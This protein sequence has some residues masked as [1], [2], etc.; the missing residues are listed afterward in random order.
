MSLNF[1]E[2]VMIIGGNGNEVPTLQFWKKGFK[3]AGGKVEPTW[4]DVILSG[5]TAL[6]L[7]NSK[8]NGLNYVK[9]FGATEQVPEEYIDSVT[10]D[11]KCEQRNLPSEYTQVEYLESSGT[12]YIDTGIV[13]KSVATITTVGQTP[14]SVEGKPNSFWGF[15]GTSTNLPRW[16]WAIYQNNW[17]LDLNTTVSSGV[18][19]DTNKHTFV[20]YCFLR[21]TGGLLLY[22]ASVD[23]QVVYE[24]AK[25]VSGV[26]KYTSN[27]LSAYLFARNNN[28]TAG[29]FLSCR[30]FSYEIVQ[31]GIKVLSLIPCRRNSDNVL[32]MYDTVTDTFLTNKGTGN[33]TAGADVTAPTPE[34]PMDIICN[35]GT[36]KVRNKSGLPLGYQRVKYL[37]CTGTQYINTGIYANTT[38]SM[39]HCGLTPTQVNTA[40][41][42]G[43][44]NTQRSSADSCN[45]FTIDNNFRLDWTFANGNVRVAYTVNTYY[46]IQ[47]SRPTCTINGVEY[48]SES[49]IIM[50]L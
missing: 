26:A 24:E 32:G 38:K 19:F 21:T 46:D 43:S 9:L 18:A 44:R 36:I 41:V 14:Q 39:F 5:N 8:A 13:L 50:V 29:N 34:T 37:E 28:N 17:L 35:N 49:Y 25:Q 23:G 40:G 2:K 31:D 47:C 6:T 16:G 22:N 12:Q 10:L 48:T 30:I 45:I 11:G 33:F 20:N 7:V 27:T 15:M 42:F 3:I 4:R 1:V